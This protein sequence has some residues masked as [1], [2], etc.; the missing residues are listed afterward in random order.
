MDLNAGNGQTAKGA[1]MTRIGAILCFGFAGTLLALS[2]M[3]PA[4]PNGQT[5]SPAGSP[6]GWAAR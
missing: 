3:H 5:L 6:A 1:Q 2:L 4:G